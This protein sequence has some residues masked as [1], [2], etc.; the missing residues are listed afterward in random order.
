MLHTYT[1]TPHAPTASPR[2]PLLTHGPYSHSVT[3]TTSSPQHTP[4]QEHLLPG[5]PRHLPNLRHILDKK[6]FS[7]PTIL[8]NISKFSITQKI[9]PKREN[10]EGYGIITEETINRTNIE[11]L[12]YKA[13]WGWWLADYRD[14]P[15]SSLQSQTS[16]K[17]RL[18]LLST[19]GQAIES[20]GPLES[21]QIPVQDMIPALVEDKKESKHNLRTTPLSKEPPRHLLKGKHN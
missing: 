18:E 9:S 5:F 6:T 14:T 19:K 10:S 1:T 20:R 3:H 17:A 12:Y 21:L 2:P 11:L 8:F 7:E 13:V 16:I 15:Q 4:P